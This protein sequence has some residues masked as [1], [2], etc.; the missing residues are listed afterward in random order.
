VMVTGRLHCV[1]WRV[2]E[3]EL[4]SWLLHVRSDPPASR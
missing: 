2:V 4:P 1:D 3:A